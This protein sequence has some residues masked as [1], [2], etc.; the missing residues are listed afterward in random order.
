MV[1][2]R[3]DPIENA[4][5]AITSSH[6]TFRERGTKCSGCRDYSLAV[7]EYELVIAGADELNLGGARYAHL[8]VGDCEFAGLR[9]RCQRAGE[10]WREYALGICADRLGPRGRVHCLADRD[11]CQRR[12]CR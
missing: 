4:P 3:D 7:G 1:V 2:R 8:E 6:V 10:R 11:D 5:D 9:L 12:R